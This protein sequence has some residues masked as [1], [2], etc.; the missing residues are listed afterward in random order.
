MLTE[1]FLSDFIW[2][3]AIG[4]PVSLIDHAILVLTGHQHDVTLKE[5]S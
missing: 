4:P 3:N 2:Y 5:V 1:L